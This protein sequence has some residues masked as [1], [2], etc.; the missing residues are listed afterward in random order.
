MIKFPLKMYY[1]YIFKGHQVKKEESRQT[2]KKPLHQRGSI[3]IE[4]ICV[5]AVLME[6][7]IS[8]VETEKENSR[9]LRGTLSEQLGRDT[10]RFD[11]SVAEFPQMLGKAHALF[12]VPHGTVPLRFCSWGGFGGGFHTSP[13]GRPDKILYAGRERRVSRVTGPHRCPRGRDAG[14]RGIRFQ[15]A[16]RRRARQVP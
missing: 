13:P 12:I 1:K 8:R 2:R 14:L 7:K 6:K 4:R 9:Y 5:E 3:S 16:N 10:S 15:P 11:D